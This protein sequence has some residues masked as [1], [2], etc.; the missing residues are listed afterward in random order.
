M[1]ETMNR[2]EIDKG[3]R[4]LIRQLWKHCYRT[5][6]SCEGFR[7]G[8]NDENKNKNHSDL[9]YIMFK[10]SGDGWFEK[11]ASRYGLK[12]FRNAPSWI[13][14][15]E[16]LAREKEITLPELHFRNAFTVYYDWRENAFKKCFKYIG[17]K[18]E[19]FIQSPF[20][21]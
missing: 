3:I 12:P 18:G 17:K 21:P 1:L 20:T 15:M 10:E 8:E 19:G 11:N 6:F 5:L 13:K 14:G 2:L 9:S 16:E 7:K 4:P